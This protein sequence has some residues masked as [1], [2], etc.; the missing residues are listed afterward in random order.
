MAPA[1]IAALI[2]AA[3]S[4]L[5]MLVNNATLERKRQSEQTKLFSELFAKIDKQ[6]E[7]SD[8]KIRGEINVIKTEIKELRGEVQKHNSVV[9]RVYK[10]EQYGAVYSEKISVANHRIEDLEK[11]RVGVDGY[12]H[13]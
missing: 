10:L 5:G 13:R 6:S 9:E 12:S 3:V 8:E 1:I 11:I 2:A 4:I 7:L